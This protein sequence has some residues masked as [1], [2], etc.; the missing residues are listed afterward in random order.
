MNCNVF[1]GARALGLERVVWASSETTLGLPFDTP[2][3]Y[4]PVDE[5]HYPYPESSY[6]LSKVVSE[7]MADD[8]AR[9]S[10]V[11]HVALRFYNIFSPTTTAASPRAAGGTR[12][13]GA[14]TCR[15]TSTRATWVRP[16]AAAWRRT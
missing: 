8:F 14:G 12:G 13:R 4:A 6:A 9:R 7:T 1:E 16:A 5:A 3:R 10:G 11:P 15:G 2:P